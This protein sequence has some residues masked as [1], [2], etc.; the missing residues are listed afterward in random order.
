MS[1]SANNI[2]LLNTEC[3]YTLYRNKDLKRT[4]LIRYYSQQSRT[5]W[6]NQCVISHRWCVKWWILSQGMRKRCGLGKY[7]SHLYI[8]ENVNISTSEKFPRLPHIFSWNCQNNVRF[9]F[10]NRNYGDFYIF[11][12][13]TA[14]LTNQLQTISWAYEAAGVKNVI[15]LLPQSIASIL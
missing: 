14:K 11:L 8:V 9:R 3:L 12:C 2:L 5:D 15:S 7:F 13:W 10:M 4:S 1:F 6:I